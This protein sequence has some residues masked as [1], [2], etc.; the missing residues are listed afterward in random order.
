MQDKSIFLLNQSKSPLAEDIVIHEKRK[1]LIKAKKKDLILGL[2]L[3]AIISEV[4][5]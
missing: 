2:R 3:E 4:F 1:K 5:Y